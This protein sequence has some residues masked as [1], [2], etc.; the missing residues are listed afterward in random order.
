MV[1]VLWISF[2][3]IIKVLDYSVDCTIFFFENAGEL[4]II[5]LRRKKGARA[6]Q[7]TPHTTPH[8]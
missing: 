7:H 3:E 5:I 6:L 2:V 1:K 4:R 8:K